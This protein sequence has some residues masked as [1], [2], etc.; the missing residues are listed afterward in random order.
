MIKKDA[1][2][3]NFSEVYKINFPI[4]T[5]KRGIRFNFSNFGVFLRPLSLYLE[6]MA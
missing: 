6:G 1:K 4:I 5:N 3:L 2:V